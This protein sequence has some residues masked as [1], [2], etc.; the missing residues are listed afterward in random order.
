MFN[1]RAAKT[2]AKRSYREHF[3]LYI[4]MC[5]VTAFFG[6]KYSINSISS[7]VL[8]NAE[9]GREIAQ[10]VSAGA[11][12]SDMLYEFMV[13]NIGVY[14]DG[15]T[16]TSNME[17]AKQKYEE[18]KNNAVKI[19]S[20][21]LA[22]K[23]GEFAKIANMA[24]TGS[25][26]NVVFG[27]IRSVVKSDRAALTL[28]IIFSIIVRLFIS[29]FIFNVFVVIMAR[30]FLEGRTYEKIQPRSFFWL[31]RV[32]RWSRVAWI[33]T[34]RQ[35]YEF[36]WALTII[37]GII[38]YFSY[39]MV[40]YIIAENPDMTANQAITLSRRM[41]KG[42]KFECF[43]LM[44]SFILWDIAGALTYDILSVV[45]VSPY[46]EAA[47]T[48]YYVELRRQAKEQGIEGSELLNDVYLFEKADPGVLKETYADIEQL[49]AETE[50]FTDHYTGARAFFSNVF[51]IVPMYTRRTDAIDVNKVKKLRIA[52]YRD[53]I[54]GQTYPQRLNPIPE[55]T[56]RSRV[57]TI[58]YTRSYS[59]TSII[60][61]FFIASFIGWAWEM[62][63]KFVEVG[64]VVNRGFMHGPWLPI[65]GGGA[66]LILILL[67]KFRHY[68]LVEFFAA[69]V[70][71]GFVE[72]YTAYY[73]EMTHD[74]QKWWDYSGYFMNI[75]GR[76]CAEGLLVFGIGG[77]AFVYFCAPML[78][79]LLRRLRLKYALPA[80]LALMVVFFSDL[81]YSKAHP[82]QGK[83][84]TDY[85]VASADSSADE[86]ASE[87]SAAQA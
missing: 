63:Y 65:Y 14:V 19:G 44:L 85:E 73:L 1:R 26:V 84:I 43:K 32:K 47:F 29:C 2:A 56:K 10:T 39:Y 41:M 52:H 8:K 87:S 54:D 55:G 74:G 69:I 9:S 59:V 7:A 38:K 3:L 66:L 23:D 45:F 51:G 46:K 20:V 16:I 78:D 71:C 86:P 70:L 22:M 12:K 61:M 58:F 27:G 33:I 6:L 24:T 75:N 64:E 67:K 5:L 82:N 50:A 77:M 42:H 72:Y 15:E 68:P 57:E 30:I 11:D 28:L 62:I 53:V 17:E 83:G 4:F 40:P 81:A 49:R 79:N 34:V 76:V 35:I 36:L 48:E 31:I 80:C 37:G 13:G 60:L 18:N 21:E 25:Y